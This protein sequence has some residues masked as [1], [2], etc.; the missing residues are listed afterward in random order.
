MESSLLTYSLHLVRVHL[1]LEEVLQTTFLLAHELVR[2]YGRKSL[3]DRC[4]IK[5]DLQK[6]FDSLDWSFLWDVLHAMEFPE[7]FI[8]WIKGCVST[9]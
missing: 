4:A 2:G 6:A 8:D 5:I 1:S 9:S 3:S 7:K